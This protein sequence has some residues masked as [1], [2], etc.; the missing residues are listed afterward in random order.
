MRP[1]HLH[2]RPCLSYGPWCG[3]QP[4]SVFHGLA[5]VCPS[6]PEAI[7]HGLAEREQRRL[8]NK[9]APVG[10]PSGPP[11]FPGPPR[12]FFSELWDVSIL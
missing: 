11:P 12:E 8:P 9:R 5:P 10:A 1:S 4:P 7:P 2:G 3:G 6:F